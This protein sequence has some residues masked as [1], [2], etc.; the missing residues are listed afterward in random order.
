[1][2]N[3]LNAYKD[4]HMYSLYSFHL[5]SSECEGP[6]CCFSCCFVFHQNVLNESVID[7]LK[8]RRTI[9]REIVFYLL[10]VIFSTQQELLLWYKAIVWCHWWHNPQTTPSLPRPEIL[11]FVYYKLVPKLS[12]YVTNFLRIFLVLISWKNWC[13]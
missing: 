3:I 12:K 11:T 1:M 2:C 13:Y 6:P 4:I 9:K 5:C 8:K 7:V 10:F